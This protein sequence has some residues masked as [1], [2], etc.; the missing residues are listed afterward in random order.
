MMRQP[1]LIIDCQ[2]WLLVFDSFSCIGLNFDL[3]PLRIEAHDL[4]GGNGYYA[5]ANATMNTLFKLGSSCNVLTNIFAIVSELPSIF[6]CKLSP[7]K[8]KLKVALFAVFFTAER[9]VA[10]LAGDLLATFFVAVLFAAGFLVA[11]VFDFG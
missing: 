6:V 8:V 5:N 4:V 1:D 10:F 7:F 9:L 2:K 3:L 11:I